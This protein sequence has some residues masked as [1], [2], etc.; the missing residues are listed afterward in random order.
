M[1]RLESDLLNYEPKNETTLGLLRNKLGITD[2]DKLDQVERMI[3]TRKLALLKLQPVN[4]PFNVK[5]YLD[6]HK[7]LFEDIYPFA[8]EIRSEVISKPIPF[9]EKEHVPFCLPG[10]INQNL[11]Y[12]LNEATARVRYINSKEKLLS[13]IIPLYAELDIIH[14]FREGNG[15]TLREFIRQFISYICE[16]NN[17]EPYYLDYGDVDRDTYISA[18]IKA[19]VC[20]DYSELTD[21]FTKIL[22]IDEDKV[23]RLSN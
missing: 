23:Q 14:P 3:T 1:A 4:P 19:D 16:I 20:V 17:L 13:F 11:T 22:K 2:K 15:R 9:N 18:I 7:Y 10:Y 5:H 21:V 6:I 12:I 8:G